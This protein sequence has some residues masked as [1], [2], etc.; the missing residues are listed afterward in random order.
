[1]TTELIDRAIVFSFDSANNVQRS[2]FTLSNFICYSL[3]QKNYTFV[4]ITCNPNYNYLPR[5]M[6][7][8]HRHLSSV[9]TRGLKTVR[10]QQSISALKKIRKRDV[11]LHLE[12]KNLD[13]KEKQEQM[14]ALKKETAQLERFS[15]LSC[16]GCGAR[17]QYKSP[18]NAGFI[19]REI[20][21]SWQTSSNSDRFCGRCEGLADEDTPSRAY[22]IKERMF[23]EMMEKLSGNRTL[24]VL[25]CDVV[26]FPATLPPNIEH[27]L[28]QGSNVIIALNKCDTI[29][30]YHPE[31]ME[32]IQGYFN[33]IAYNE[34]VRSRALDINLIGVSC[35]SAVTGYGLPELAQSIENV[36][37]CKRQQPSVKTC[38]LVGLSNSGKSTL[39]NQ[40]SPLLNE[41]VDRPGSVMESSSVGTTVDY[42]EAP[43]RSRTKATERDSDEMLRLKYRKLEMI[44]TDP[45]HLS[46]SVGNSGL[47][48]ARTKISGKQGKQGG[49]VLIDTPG[50]LPDNTLARAAFTLHH[51][52]Q[53]QHV[54]L[55]PGSCI[56]LGSYKIYYVRGMLPL[57]LQVKTPELVQCTVDNAPV[58]DTLG[59]TETG[60]RLCNKLYL[61]Q[62]IHTNSNRLQND[63]VLGNMGWVTVNLLR[64]DHVTVVVF[65]PR[66][67]DIMH[68]SPGLDVVLPLIGQYGG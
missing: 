51:P 13:K 62:S 45:D 47:V 18:K 10:D 24:I 55:D 38:L 56:S 11:D 19:A 63:I 4:N 41:D 49:K 64:G 36:L 21:L 68:M 17:Y 66:L 53:E 46:T 9:C 59:L 40:L 3:S 58:E 23:A 34:F 26:G 8:L 50:V 15:S 43:I 61:L 29:G 28:P 52:L 7:P 31:S 1:M 5:M 30:D 20:L 39:F 22:S 27:L 6:S 54:Q 37:H 67:D 42:I 32:T 14:Y 48:R 57:D 44:Y 60:H 25:V 35:I 65:G 12:K 33:R 16:P 2:I